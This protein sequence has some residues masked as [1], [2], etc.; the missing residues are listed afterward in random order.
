MK[1]HKVCAVVQ[2]NEKL[3][4]TGKAGEGLRGDRT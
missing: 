4:C 2:K 3:T 1:L